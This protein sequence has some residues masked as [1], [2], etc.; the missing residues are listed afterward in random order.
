MLIMMFIQTKNNETTIIVLRDAGVSTL[1]NGISTTHNQTLQLNAH[2]KREIIGSYCQVLT[3]LV[4]DP[5]MNIVTSVL[6]VENLCIYLNFDLISHTLF[7][8]VLFL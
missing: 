5:N 8:S 1:A 4:M 6:T 3:I 7:G 2:Q